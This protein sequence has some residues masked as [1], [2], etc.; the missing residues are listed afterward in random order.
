M[1]I[2]METE[3]MLTMSNMAEQE[4]NPINMPQ[5]QRDVDAYWSER[6][7]MHAESSNLNQANMYKIQGLD[8]GSGPDQVT[9]RSEYLHPHA[10]VSPSNLPGTV[11]NDSASDHSSEHL[12]NSSDTNEDLELAALNLDCI[13]NL[14]PVR[15][16]N[17]KRKRRFDIRDISA[18]F[19]IIGSDC[20]NG[21]L[22]RQRFLPFLNQFDERELSNCVR[23]FRASGAPF[24]NREIISSITWG[25]RSNDPRCQV[26]FILPKKAYFLP[27]QPIGVSVMDL[28]KC[29]VVDTDSAFR[30]IYKGDLSRVHA[31]NTQMQVSYAMGRILE[32][33]LVVKMACAKIG[34]V[35]W[36]RQYVYNLANERRWFLCKL[37]CISPGVLRFDSQDITDDPY[38]RSI[39]SVPLL[40][41]VR[42]Q[43]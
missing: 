39:N 10:P 13:D 29:K 22:F 41:E 42:L 40:D 38:I 14:V 21:E 34:D 27:G 26:D 3:K 1:K 25:L 31:R 8:G 20:V 24:L 35:F 28:F 2:K 23:I 19:E 32:G 17:K 18:V 11:W 37:V 15:K 7:Y 16:K 5:Y 12:S 36:C 30:G 43:I 33:S 6:L 9:S 4:F